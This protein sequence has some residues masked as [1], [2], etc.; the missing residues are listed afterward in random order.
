M[1]VARCYKLSA[2]ERA[3]SR[4]G[5]G[6]SYRSCSRESSA[7]TV[8]TSVPPPGCFRACS[9]ARSADTARSSGAASRPGP[10]R[11]KKIQS[12]R[13]PNR[14]ALGWLARLRWDLPSAPL[15]PRG[16]RA[17]LKSSPADVSRACPRGEAAPLL[18]RRL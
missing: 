8:A 12:P 15:Y 9:S 4:A 5:C 16:G 14:S 1:V 13:A 11:G 3:C 17:R 10:T 7:R 18:Y 6:A 2:E